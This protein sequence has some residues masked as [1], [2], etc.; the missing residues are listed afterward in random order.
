MV[1]SEQASWRL[2]VGDVRDLGVV[3]LRFAVSQVPRSEAPG[4]PIF[5]G[6]IM[7]RFACLAPG[8]PIFSD[9]IHFLE[10]WVTRRYN[11]KIQK[12]ST[13][14]DQLRSLPS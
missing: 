1:T 12:G 6:T 7:A 9:A 8:A 4:A 5:N 11:S 10:T 13:V 3:R 2:H 14:G